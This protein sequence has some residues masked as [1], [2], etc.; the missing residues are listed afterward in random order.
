MR[1]FLSVI[2]ISYVMAGSWVAFTDDP[3]VRST[4]SGFVSL[5]EPTLAAESAAPTVATELVPSLSVYNTSHDRIGTIYAVT[6]RND[7]IK[8]VF[9]KDMDIAGEYISMVEGRVIF[10]NGKIASSGAFHE[11][12]ALN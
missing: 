5:F 3:D 1:I 9:T 2:L 4:V 7:E 6:H 12:R 10:D 8:S 11:E